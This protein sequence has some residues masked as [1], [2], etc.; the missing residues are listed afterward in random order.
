MS[1]HG[2]KTHRS[3]LAGKP[4]D[5]QLT[6]HSGKEVA[7][8]L[9]QVGEPATAVMRFTF[10]N[11]DPAILRALQEACERN[12]IEMQMAP[13]RLASPTGDYRDVTLPGNFKGKPS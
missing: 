7:E 12:G 6:L 1:I 3:V 5:I 9:E 8:I 10:E 4:V 13:A 2:K 11:A